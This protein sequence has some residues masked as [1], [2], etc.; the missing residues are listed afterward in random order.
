[1]AV[2]DADGRVVRKAIA[3]TVPR[4]A[5]EPRVSIHVL[6]APVV[7]RPCRVE[8]RAPAAARVTLAV[9]GHSTADPQVATHDVEIPASGRAIV[10]IVPTKP[11]TDLHVPETASARGSTS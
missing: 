2:T 4:P 7:G 1:V 8:L 3:V 6:D 5:V 11:V 9:A 10:T